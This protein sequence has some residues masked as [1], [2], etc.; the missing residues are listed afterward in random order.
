MRSLR[1]RLTAISV[2]LVGLGLLVASI[3][4]E[5]VSAKPAS[6]ATA[7]TRLARKAA[8]TARRRRAP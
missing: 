8:T 2:V 7:M 1:F 4:A 5:R 3:A 6:L